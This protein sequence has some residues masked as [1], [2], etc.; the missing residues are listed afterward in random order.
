VLRD[1][2]RTFFAG[3]DAAAVGREIRWRAEVDDFAGAFVA[4]V[5]AGAG[6]HG[7]I[8]GTG[9]SERGLLGDERVRIEA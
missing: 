6:E 2:S 3:R 8:A 4:E 7:R 1:G 5:E 9:G